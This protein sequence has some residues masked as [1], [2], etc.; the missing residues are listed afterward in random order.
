GLYRYENN[1][2][3]NVNEPYRAF[4]RKVILNEDSTV[5]WGNFTDSTGHLVESQKQY[6]IPSF[7]FNKNAIKFNFASPEFR[8]PEKL[9]YRY[10]LEGFKNEWSKWKNNNYANYTNLPEGK[11]TFRVQA[12]NIYGNISKDGTYTFIILSPWYRTAWAF[13][14]YVIFRALFMWFLIWLNTRRLLAQKRKLQEKVDE[15]TVEI[16]NKNKDLEKEKKEVENQKS[17][18]EKE[19]EKVEVA[20]ENLR[21]KNQEIVDSI[22]YAQKIQHALLKAETILGSRKYPSY[23]I[24]F[25]PRDMVSGDFY[26]AMENEEHLYIAA[27]DCTGHGV[28]GA[29]M[30]M[31]GI[32]FLNEITS[33]NKGIPPGELLTKL[34]SR[35]VGELVGESP[36]T[37]AKDGMDM[38]LIRVNLNEKNEEV[39]NISFAGAN[40]P[41][42]AIHKDLNNFNTEMDCINENKNI[43]KD[44]IKKTFGENS[45]GL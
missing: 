9:S 25:K 38:A 43:E 12:K 23:F 45:E 30:S 8:M 21:E 42:Y 26:W 29:M 6:K 35:V 10:K 19:R 37:G 44:N 34:R 17:I 15:A 39:K 11:Y 40:N 36:G 5:F 2:E 1:K 22:N 13:V 41:L 3:F 24:M 16:R 27:V 4:V 31:L 7:P 32:A 20:H 14:S 33:N 18:A 28:P